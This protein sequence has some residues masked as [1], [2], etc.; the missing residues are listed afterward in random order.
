MQLVLIC[1]FLAGGFGFF[2]ALPSVLGYLLKMLEPKPNLVG[3]E[4][5]FN[6]QALD[7][8]LQKLLVVLTV[9]L[10]NLSKGLRS[11]CLPLRI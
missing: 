4:K 6:S 5:T 11:Y 1:F 2:S 8:G 9:V 10:K 7:I 3:G